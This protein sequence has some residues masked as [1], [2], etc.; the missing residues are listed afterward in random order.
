[1]SRDV[2]TRIAD[3]ASAVPGNCALISLGG[4][5][6]P[7][8]QSMTYGEL[9]A[10]SARVGAGLI[11]AGC[12]GRPV[13][14]CVETPSSFLCLFLGAIMAGAVPI[15][16]YGAGSR[17]KRALQEAVA[18]NA[19]PALLV[20]EGKRQSVSVP[21][22]D[23]ADLMNAAVNAPLP[24]IGG[25]QRNSP[26]YLQYS[27]GSTGRPKGIM[28][29]PRNLAT[30]VDALA[31]AYGVDNHSVM[32]NWMPVFHDFGLVFGLMTPLA[33]GATIVALRPQD[34]ARQPALWL[35]ALSDY[36]GTVSGGPDFIYRACVDAISEEARAG[37]D[38]SA[39]KTA[40]VGAE[41]IRK[42]TMEA[43]EKRFRENGLSAGALRPSY[44]LAEATL[45][46]SGDV[47]DE[48]TGQRQWR[49]MVDPAGQMQNAAVSCGHIAQGCEV[50]IRL[51][52][53]E[54]DE[55]EVG[56]VY[57]AGDGVAAGYWNNTEATNATFVTIDGSRFLRT[58]DLGFLSGN[59]L[60]LT[61]RLKDVIIHAGEKHYSEDIE[62]TIA[63]LDPQLTGS[64]AVAFGVPV[65]EE[66]RVVVACELSSSAIE[67]S[68]ALVP[69][70]KRAVLE[71]H[72]LVV[73]ECLWLRHNQLARTT[74][75]K[76][77]RSEARRAYLAG[78]LAGRNHTAPKEC[79]DDPWVPIL[80]GVLADLADHHGA[81]LPANV[82]AT[83]RFAE[84]GL[85]SIVAMRVVASLTD[86]FGAALPVTRFIGDATVGNAAAE[87]ARSIR[88]GLD[89][90]GQRRADRMLKRIGERASPPRELE[91]AI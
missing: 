13:L 76:L 4:D 21:Q 38:L 37:L 89:D 10:A 68:E 23:V 71:M 78:E 14:S 35:Q 30:N 39:W 19:Q 66:E 20:H 18:E 67:H 55:G 8:G 27:S 53:R 52:D 25:E 47:A 28:V 34:V 29:T 83:S 62:A 72:G 31:R 87:I 73:Q 16:L 57:V 46:V 50:K 75:G 51:E 24:K 85:D 56:E 70:I 2:F 64:R 91:N 45:I 59:E 79:R 49:S 48:D 44:G 9:H 61:G 32:V 6:K 69:Q 82:T 36:R 63:A 17:R 7:V 15:P 33:F 80:V 54:A 40:V 22:M 1:M 41:P 90:E 3:H 88:A 58:G 84:L 81:K 86:L 42:T 26:A 74:S 77:R 11:A 60:F 5:G 43:F 12:V 65:G